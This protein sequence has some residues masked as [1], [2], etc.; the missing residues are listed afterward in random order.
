MVREFRNVFAW[1]Y[2][3]LKTYDKSIIQYTTPLEGNEKPHR[4]K[5][6]KINLKLAPLVKKELQKMVEAKIIVPIRYSEWLSNTVPY[7][8][9]TGDV[10]VCV[11]FKNLNAVSKKDNYPLS[12]MELLL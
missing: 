4:Q 5:L 7:K 3:E 1:S 2:D 8:K 12:N 9:K 11:D 6:R 10:R